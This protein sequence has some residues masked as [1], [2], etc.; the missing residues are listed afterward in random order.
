MPNKY[1]IIVSILSIVIS[2]CNTNKKEL[3]KS[4]DFTHENL[5][6]A[7]IEGPAVDN[8]GNLYAVNFK[9]EGTIGM[10]DQTGYASLFIEL[11]EGSTG[12]GIRFDKLG[13]MYIADYTGH[14]VLKIEKGKNEVEVFA[15]D[16]TAYQPNDLAI[17]PNGILFASDPDWKNSKGQIWKVT[18]GKFTLLETNMGTTNGIEVDPT[19]TKLYVNESVQRNIWVYDLDH[20]GTISN[21]KLFYKFQNFGMDGMRCDTKGNLYVC[22]YDAGKVVVLNPNGEIIREIQLIGKKPTNITFGGKDKKQCF[23]TLA[24]RGCFETFKADYPGKEF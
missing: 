12:N 23:V 13:N 16:S 6:T 14:N 3:D 4:I 19:G 1:L 8:K 5:F 7:G 22:R 20:S 10:V 24:D 2:S 21:K 15:N 18:K 11:P 9:K 17:A